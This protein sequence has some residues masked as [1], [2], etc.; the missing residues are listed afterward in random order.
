MAIGWVKIVFVVNLM[1]NRSCVWSISFYF[2]LSKSGFDTGGR[3]IEVKV[4]SATGLP[5]SG[6]SKLMGG[7]A[8]GGG[9]LIFDWRYC[10]SLESLNGELF[11]VFHS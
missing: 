5:F 8:G 2:Q 1:V 3:Q 6:R 4:I 7:K 11:E 10:Q 9:I